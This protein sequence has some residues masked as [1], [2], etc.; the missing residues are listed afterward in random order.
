MLPYDNCT[1]E[2]T[3]QPL[4]V[5]EQKLLQLLLAALVSEVQNRLKD[6]PLLARI[7]KANLLE[8]KGNTFTHILTHLIL[9]LS[10]I[11]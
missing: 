8:H 11:Y 9:A 5:T 7:K 10:L 1:V 4:K 6:A 2:L 3:R